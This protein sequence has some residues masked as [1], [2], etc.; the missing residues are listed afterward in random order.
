MYWSSQHIMRNTAISKSISQRKF[1]SIYSHL[2]FADNQH[3]NAKD[4]F[5][6]IQPL[7]N[8]LNK[9]FLENGPLSSHI[10]VDECIVPYYGRHCAKQFIK[11]KPVRFGYKVNVCVN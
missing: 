10:S 5:A 11:G 2:H 3:L 9:T 6:K 7:L 4:K 1:E 8:N